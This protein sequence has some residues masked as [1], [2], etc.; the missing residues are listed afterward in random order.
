MT[1]KNKDIENV[2]EKVISRQ[3]YTYTY[4]ERKSIKYII[5]FFYILE[6]KLHIINVL[7]RHF[8]SLFGCSAI[9]IVTIYFY[10][11]LLKA[12]K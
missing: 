8:I 5:P 4:A 2:I 3:L 10:T 11:N 9:H 1:L 7:A 6:V 12:T